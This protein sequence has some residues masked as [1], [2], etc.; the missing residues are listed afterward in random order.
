[1][2]KYRGRFLFT[3]TSKPYISYKISDIKRDE[4]L[5]NIKTLLQDIKKLQ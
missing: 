2:D 1:M 3:A 4:I 5:D